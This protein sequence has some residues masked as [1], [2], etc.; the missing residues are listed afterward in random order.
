MYATDRD[1]AWSRRALSAEPQP[2][3]A[4]S[5]RLAPVSP[6]GPG[7]LHVFTT[8]PG[9][10][11]SS[12]AP[13]AG[14]GAGVAVPSHTKS[15]MRGA[16]PWPN[17]SYPAGLICSPSLRRRRDGAVAGAVAGEDRR[18]CGCGRRCGR[19]CGRG[20]GCGC[21]C[22]WKWDYTY[23]ISARAILYSA[24]YTI[25]SIERTAPTGMAAPPH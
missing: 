1:R 13:D 18:G 8:A 17:A 3:A 19:G 23:T 22:G 9:H 2:P 11:R 4:R 12:E 20:C 21:G 14:A 6:N 7:A 15:R 5:L 16:R 25:L 10:R 24:S